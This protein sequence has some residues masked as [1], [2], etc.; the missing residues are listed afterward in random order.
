[1][2][3]MSGSGSAKPTTG[4]AGLD[5]VLKGVL[6]GDNYMAFDN[7]Q[8]TALPATYYQHVNWTGDT[9]GTNNPVTVV[10]NTNKILQAVFSEILTT[11][12][13]T[14]WWW[15]ASYGYTTSFETAVTTI[16]S[17]G[18]PLCQSYIAGLNPNDPN[19][20]LR[21]SVAPGASSYGLVLN[22]TAFFGALAKTR[23]PPLG[24]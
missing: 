19:S 8:I 21:L 22:W 1:M 16:G 12:H 4:L 20:Q 23:P 11:N 6:P 7:Y 15:L 10:I 5:G 17:N 3:S 9:A 18:I 14:P 2:E 24:S 13:P